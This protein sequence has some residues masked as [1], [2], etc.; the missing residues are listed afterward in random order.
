[1]GG[2]PEAYLHTGVTSLARLRFLVP[3]AAAAPTTCTIGLDRSFHVVERRKLASATAMRSPWPIA[4]SAR[5]PARGWP[6]SSF[7]GRL[8]HIC[9]W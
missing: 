8:D 3:T 1:L 9:A 5:R 6:Q 4:A 7:G 2:R